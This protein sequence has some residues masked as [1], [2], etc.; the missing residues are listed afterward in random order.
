M[1]TAIPYIMAA[2]LIGLAIWY[3]LGKPLYYA[4]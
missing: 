2:I 1:R 3:A 4:N